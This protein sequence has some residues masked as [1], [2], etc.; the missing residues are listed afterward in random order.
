MLKRI[1]FYVD[2]VLEWLLIVIMG[3]MVINVLWQVFTRFIIKN[4]STYT[5]ELA[6]FLLIWI[7]LFGASY[8]VSKRLHL[9]I[10]YFTLKFTGKT[11]LLSGLF[12]DLCVF[13]F[14]LFAM[15]VG[16]IHLVTLTLA[17]EQ[18]S[19]ALQIKLG[20]VY[21]VLP[22]SGLLIMFYAGLQMSEHVRQLLVKGSYIEEEHKI[23]D[24]LD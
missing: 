9:A 15:V 14:A 1:R 19:A 3:V 17:L 10:D 23:A 4:P 16:G 2:K 12:I 20:Y 7:A 6:R 22:L 11:K 24:A 13:V 8:A 18:V 5:E 21:L